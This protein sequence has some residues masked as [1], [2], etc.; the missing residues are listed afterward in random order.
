[1]NVTEIVMTYPPQS[2]GW[3]DQQGGYQ[4]DQ[5]GGWQDPAGGYGSPVS[6]QPAYVDPVSGQPTAYPA[7]TSGYAQQQPYPTSPG[8]A[9]Y[10]GYPGYGTPVMVPSQRTNGMAIAAMVVSLVSLPGLFCYGVGGIVIGM[11]GAILGHVARR[12]VTERGEG[13]SG[14]ALAGIIIGWIAVAVGVVVLGLFIWLVW[15]AS[16]LPS[17]YP[18]PYTT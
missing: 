17:T 12:Q 5:P 1:M 15:W 7:D 18:S 8:Y 6:G 9:G 16:N 3:P 14:M 13:G 2:G 4:Q 10:P 11:V